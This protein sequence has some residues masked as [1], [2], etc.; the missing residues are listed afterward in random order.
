[1]PIER[2]IVAPFALLREFAPH[3]H[4][5]LAGMAEHES[6]VGAQICESLPLVAGHAAQKRA[7]SVHDLIVRKRQD[8]ILEIGV[9]HA[10]RDTLMMMLSM[11]GVPADEIECVIHPAHVPFV[12]EAKPIMVYGARDLRPGS[13]LFRNGGSVRETT[14]DLGI[15]SLQEC[16]GF[17]AKSVYSVAIQPEQCVCDQEVLDFDSSVIED[18]GAPIE[19]PALARVG[20]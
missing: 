2:V 11:N 7:L 8:E 6:V 1:M 17:D 12:T 10:E 5:L 3:E 15:E 19:V 13:R 20:M 18:Q 4:Q 9:E 16:D 14:I